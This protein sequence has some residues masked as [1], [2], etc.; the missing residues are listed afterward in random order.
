MA[1]KGLKIFSPPSYLVLPNVSP[2]VMFNAV[3]LSYFGHG[4]LFKDDYHLTR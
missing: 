3:M 4:I 1:V 2:E